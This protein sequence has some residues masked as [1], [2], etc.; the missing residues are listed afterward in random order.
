MLF[1]FEWIFKCFKQ[2][3][4]FDYVLKF[5]LNLIFRFNSLTPNVD[6]NCIKTDFWQHV[7]V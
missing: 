3:P 6:M 2:K 1:S 5:S 4:C 7:Q